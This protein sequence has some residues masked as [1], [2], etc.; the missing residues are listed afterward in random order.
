MRF[1]RHRQ[2]ELTPEKINHAP[3]EQ[4][5]STTQQRTVHADNGKK[6]VRLHFKEAEQ[7]KPS[8]LAH[9]A[10]EALAAEIHKQVDDSVDE[11]V[12][13]EV[14]HRTEQAV[15]TSYRFVGERSHKAKTQSART[16]TRT[17]PTETT[18]NPLSRWLQRQ[19]IKRQYAAARSGA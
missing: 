5:T 16:A 17:E 18:T 15:E 13:V 10:K 6:T 9:V 3:P 11:N 2:A 14:A 1:E 8:K 12:A 19:A 7:K 4:N